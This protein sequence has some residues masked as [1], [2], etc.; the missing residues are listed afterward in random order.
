MKIKSDKRHFEI[1][2]S[3][4]FGVIWKVQLK[5]FFTLSLKIGSYIDREKL[6]RAKGYRYVVIRN[7]Y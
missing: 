7:S 1:I 4:R 3:C 2:K 6:T 5:T